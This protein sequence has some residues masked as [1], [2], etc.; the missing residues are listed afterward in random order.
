MARQS[1]MQPNR[2]INTYTG[3]YLAI[4]RYTQ[5]YRESTAIQGYT[6]L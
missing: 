4:Q 1:Y 6:Q 2:A 5:L 3:L